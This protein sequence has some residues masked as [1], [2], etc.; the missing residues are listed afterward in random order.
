[1]VESISSST[2]MIQMQQMNGGSRGGGSQIF[3]MKPDISELLASLFG[4]YVY[5]IIKFVQDNERV[6]SKEEKKK[7][8]IFFLI[9]KFL[10][11]FI[12]FIIF[13]GFPTSINLSTIIML[14]IFFIVL[15]FI[16]ISKPWDIG[17]I[18]YL[19]QI[20]SKKK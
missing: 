11:L 7:L 17:G 10:I 13:Q 3:S 19:K 6:L 12:L 18:E 1:M 5:T 8:A 14:L 2:A 4:A 9:I 15:Y 20:R 16:L